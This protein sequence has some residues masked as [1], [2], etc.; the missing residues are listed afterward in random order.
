VV[1]EQV[2]ALLDRSVAAEGYVIR[3]PPASAVA[4]HRV[5][6]SKIDFEA[7]AKQFKEGRKRTEAEKLR[8]ILERKLEDMLRRN[9]TRQQFLDRFQQMIAE[10]NCGIIGAD[11]FFERLSQFAK[12]LDEEDRRAV[13]ENLDEEELAVL[14]LLLKPRIELTKTER[15]QVKK[16]AKDLLAILKQEKLVLDWRKKQQSRAAVRLTIEEY[17]DALPEAFLTVAYEQKC[18]SVYQHVFESYF[19]SGYGIYSTAA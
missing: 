19:G 1:T 11:E 12:A 14:D 18:E 10:Y 8:A 6:L 15:E 3:H 16:V 13:S 5:D 2:E 7:L 4:E 17:L 9:R